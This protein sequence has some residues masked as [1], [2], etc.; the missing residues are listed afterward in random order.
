MTL[1]VGFDSGVVR[2]FDVLATSVVVEL[3]QHRSRVAGVTFAPDGDRLYSSGDDGFICAYQRQ[4]GWQPVLTAAHD[5]PAPPSSSKLGPQPKA[6]SSH[7]ALSP[8]GELLAVSVALRTELRGGQINVGGSATKVRG[9][10]ARE[11]RGAASNFVQVYRAHTLQP[12]VRI[13][14]PASVAALARPDSKW[15]MPASQELGRKR[16]RAAKELP[17][18]PP[19]ATAFVF[20]PDSRAVILATAHSGAYGG[21][22]RLIRFRFV[23]RG[24]AEPP[25]STV[26]ECGAHEEWRSAVEA[27]IINAHSADIVSLA[28]SPNGMLVVAGTV[29]GCVKVWSAALKCGTAQIFSSHCAA[30]ASLAWAEKG[31]FFYVP[32]HFTRILLTI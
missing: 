32:L 1:V 4:R 2:I 16:N 28:I 12:L 11:Y 8:S 29:D 31:E 17:P 27:E 24:A 5:V 18:P 19:L 30:V 21:G 9:A 3:C 15:A 23:A 26:A 25:D 20:T 13:W 14:P 10:V 6:P 7:F 22:R